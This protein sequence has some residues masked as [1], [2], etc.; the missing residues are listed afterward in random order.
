MT[1][2]GRPLHARAWG[3]HGVEA[4]NNQAATDE[5][6]RTKSVRTTLAQAAPNLLVRQGYER[7][8]TG[9]RKVQG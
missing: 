5:K 9:T 1:R 4:D 3:K 6:P 7:P 2:S 8:Y